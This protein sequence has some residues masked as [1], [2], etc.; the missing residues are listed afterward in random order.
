MNL[1]EEV[2]HGESFSEEDF[3]EAARYAFHQELYDASQ[4]DI[5]EYLIEQISEM[6]PEEVAEFWGK[7]KNIAKKVGSGVLKVASVAAPI[8]GTALGAKFGAPHLGKMVGGMAGNLAGAG[9]KALD[10]N[11]RRSGR[12]YRRRRGG[13]RRR[14]DPRVRGVLRRSG[15]HLRRAGRA[16]IRGANRYAAQNPVRPR[17]RWGEDFNENSSATLS[18]V[19]D[20][21]Q[22]Q[23]LMFGRAHGDSHTENITEN[24][25]DY[26]DLMETVNYLTEGILADYYKEDLLDDDTYAVNEYGELIVNNPEERA[27]RA[28]SLIEELI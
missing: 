12:S 18:K 3:Y 14:L 4:E 13:S 17:Y 23:A 15:R 22:F 28:E 26:I 9:A 6:S 21:P 11:I 5:D 25:Y 19:I 7:L 16:A 8:A 2:F 24:D 20:N 27:E 10:R 1:Y